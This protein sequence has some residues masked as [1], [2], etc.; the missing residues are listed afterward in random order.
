MAVAP[1]Q[2][3]SLA[4]KT[5]RIIVPLRAGRDIRHPRTGAFGEVGKALGATV[6][7]DNK[8]G[9]NGVLAVI[10]SKSAPDGTTL[11]LTD[12]SG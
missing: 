2:A 8:P 12:V 1:A 6:V 9:A 3:Q 4:G 10:W 7:V 5:I 11:L